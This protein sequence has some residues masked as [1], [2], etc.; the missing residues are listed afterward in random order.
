MGWGNAHRWKGEVVHTC[1]SLHAKAVHCSRHDQQD[2]CCENEEEVK[3]AKKLSNEHRKLHLKKN[4][5][6]I[7]L[8]ELFN[9]NFLTHTSE[10]KS[11]VLT[12]TKS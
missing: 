7:D 11:E 10:I 3:R 12:G 9:S 4:V 1:V 6:Q 8:L 5:K 2:E